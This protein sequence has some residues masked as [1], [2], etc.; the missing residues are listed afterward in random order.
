MILTGR[1]ASKQISI[2][3]HLLITAF[4]ACV[5]GGGSTA[6]FIENFTFI[7]FLIQLDNGD[8]VMN[9]VAQIFSG[10]IKEKKFLGVSCLHFSTCLKMISKAFC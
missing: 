8:R 2:F 6:S 5:L 1:V 9:F 7:V 3:L 10:V 4:P